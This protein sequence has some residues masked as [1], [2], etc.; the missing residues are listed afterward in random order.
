M[1]HEWEKR[2]F[3]RHCEIH[4]RVA[5][6]SS[7]DRMSDLRSWAIDNNL[8]GFVVSRTPK[9]SA[10][11]ASGSPADGNDDWTCDNRSKQTLR[12][13]STVRK[14]EQTARQLKQTDHKETKQRPDASILDQNTSSL[15]VP[16]RAIFADQAS[17][18][19]SHA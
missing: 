19:P 11:A 9:V 1:A 14:G 13:K 4:S 17:F 2:S 6:R 12:H 16:R 18:R 15:T 5:L 3:I 10:R 8:C 7:W